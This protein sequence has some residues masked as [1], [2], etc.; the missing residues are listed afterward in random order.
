[1]LLVIFLHSS[2][3][4]AGWTNSGEMNLENSQMSLPSFE[5]NGQL[6]LSGKSKLSFKEFSGSGIIKIKSGTTVIK[7]E[8]FLFNGT[9]ECNGT[10]EIQTLIPESQITI[11]RQGNGTITIKSLE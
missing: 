2:V 1:M 8:Q 6:I 4:Y 7:A 10:L 5:N 3:A 11:T 9:I